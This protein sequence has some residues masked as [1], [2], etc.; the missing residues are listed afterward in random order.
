MTRL[1][2]LA[3]CAALALVLVAACAPRGSDALYF[4]VSESDRKCFLE[5]LPSDTV[6]K[7]K[8]ELEA[9]DEELER[10]MPSPTTG[11]HFIIRDPSKNIIM[12][13]DYGAA[14]TVSFTSHEPGEHTICLST[15]TTRYFG[16]KTLKVDIDISQGEEANDYKEIMKKDKLTELQVRVRQVMDQVQQI[17]NEQAYQRIREAKFRDT[18]ESTNA[19]VLWWSIGQTVILLGTT[20][21]QAHHLR[22]FFKKIKIV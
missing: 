6:V 3:A 8:Y 15:N 7:V 5:E 13:K 22:S 19:R 21:W 18:S 16:G 2:L 10:F 20:L 9:Y 12:Q 14:G 11:L 4:L 17:A 1:V